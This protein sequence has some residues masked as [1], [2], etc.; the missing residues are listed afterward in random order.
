MVLLICIHYLYPQTTIAHTLQESTKKDLC[1]VPTIP[2]NACKKIVNNIAGHV[3]FVNR[4]F[5]N[6]M[7]I[8]IYNN[9][10]NIFTLSLTID[11]SCSQMIIN[12]ID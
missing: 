5:V 1:L 8:S 7:L 9:N 11:D 12:L 10:N 6:T 2:I 3:A 4:G